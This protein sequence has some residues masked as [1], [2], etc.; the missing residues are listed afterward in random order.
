MKINIFVAF[1]ATLLAG[2]F[3]VSAA[4]TELPFG[5]TNKLVEYYLQHTDTVRFSLWLPGETMN[6]FLG[7][8]YTTETGEPVNSL[9]RRSQAE[10]VAFI[11]RK[12]QEMTLFAL[13]EHFTSEMD[14][15]QFI[16]RYGGEATMMRKGQPYAQDLFG[17]L[18][19]FAVTQY[20]GAFNFSDNAFAVKLSQAATASLHIPFLVKGIKS[21]QLL[22]EDGSSPSIEAWT[23]MGGIL[24]VENT[25]LITPANGQL[26]IQYEDG[27]EEVTDTEN[28]NTLVTYLS[29]SLAEGSSF[30]RLGVPRV[31][32]DKVELRYEA[33]DSE[34]VQIELSTDGSRWVPYPY[35]P[36]S[37]Y[38]PVASSGIKTASVSSVRIRTATAPKVSGHGFYRARITSPLPQQVE[39]R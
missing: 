5:G 1:V 34:D 32:D 3:S 24:W 35:L 8:V 4:I 13:R 28:G 2:P 29:P 6:I 22:M 11:E 23:D 33:E 36:V 18:N 14:G 37:E 19:Y 30:K 31:I 38:P 20:D 26:R 10:F 17:Q 9:A 39:K 16:V 15:E 7:R 12:M 27:R 25:L 21:A